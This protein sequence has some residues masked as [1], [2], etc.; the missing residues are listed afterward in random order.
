MGKIEVPTAELRVCIKLMC[1]AT[2]R[3]DCSSGAGE[4]PQAIS[5]RSLS[6]GSCVLGPGPVGDMRA[7]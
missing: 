6:A 3:N 1:M 2:V 5:E 7:A 4:E